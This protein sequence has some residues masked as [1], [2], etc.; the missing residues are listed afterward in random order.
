MEEFLD[1]FLDYL[2]VERGLARNTIISYRKDLSYYLSFLRGRKV[3]ALSDTTKEHITDFMF[4]QKGRG[5]SANSIAR[6]LAAM[7]MFY[8]FLQREK[9]IP[10]DPTALL[11]SPKLWKK[12]PESLSLNEV[13]ALLNAPNLR[14]AQGVRDRAILEVMY[15]T[16]MR[17][18]E[19]VD[20]K[21]DNIN[22]DV[23]FLRCIGKG[24][25]ERVIP[26]GRKAISGVDRYISQ[27]RPALLKGRESPYVFLNRF[28]GRISRQSLWKI[29]KKYARVANIKKPIKPHIIRHSFATHLLERGADL[30]SLQEMLG[31]SDIST[32]Q[33]YTH[34]DRDRLKKVHKLFHPRG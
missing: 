27:A 24:N 18:S 1:T 28:G 5:L 12:I 9:V 8:R 29:I 17:A 25:K 6:G 32:T 31:H 3:A 19:V 7:R 15:A 26:L 16:G 4:K 13:E 33:I 21:L 23:G 2:S 20:L 14:N 34:V 30:R 10:R 22:K 11:D